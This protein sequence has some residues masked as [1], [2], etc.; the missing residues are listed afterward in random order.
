MYNEIEHSFLGREPF[1]QR[2]VWDAD[3]GYVFTNEDVVS[4]PSVA[5]S[6][7]VFWITGEAGRPQFAKRR[8]KRFCEGIESSAEPQNRTDID[9]AKERLKALGYSEDDF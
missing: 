4:P 8:A 9:D 2:S 3:G 7:T 6:E 1:E 5:L